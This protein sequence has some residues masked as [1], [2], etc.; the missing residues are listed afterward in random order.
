VL[1]RKPEGRRP[2][3]RHEDNIKTDVTLDG[4]AWTGLMWLRAE[5][6]GKLL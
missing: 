3:K 6:S 1:V 5:T 4:K 2:R